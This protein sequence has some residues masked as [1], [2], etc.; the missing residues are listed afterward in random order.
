[1][2]FIFKYNV[3]SPAKSFF[4]IINGV[5]TVNRKNDGGGSDFNIQIRKLLLRKY[6]SHEQ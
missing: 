2:S 6:K 4:I 3:Q 1:M 5:S